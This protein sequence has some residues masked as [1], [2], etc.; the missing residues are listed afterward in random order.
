MNTQN[1]D[2]LENISMKLETLTNELSRH[3]SEI[4]GINHIK[5]TFETLS[6]CIDDFT[7]N[8]NT[9]KRYMNSQVRKIRSAIDLTNYEL[10]TI[11]NEESCHIAEDELKEINERYHALYDF[12]KKDNFKVAKMIGLTP[13]TIAEKALETD[14]E[15]ESE[16]VNDTINETTTDTT[17]TETFSEN[18]NEEVSTDV[19]DD[20]DDDLIIMAE[21]E[22]ITKEAAP[23]YYTADQLQD[24]INARNESASELEN[25]EDSTDDDFIIVDNEESSN[26]SENL[27][28][29]TDSTDNVKISG[30]ETLRRSRISDYFPTMRTRN[31]A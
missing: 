22:P 13:D 16:P 10:I 23:D 17:P 21:N 8:F 14:Y 5:D 15:S 11:L 18:V 31:N 26:E 6:K 19:V 1:L 24:A 3:E 30:I 4:D 2:K 12:L 27:S 25:E 28:N 20:I 7:N 9:F 29:E